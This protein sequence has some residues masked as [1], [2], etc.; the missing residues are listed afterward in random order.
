MRL[1]T[2]AGC[3]SLH[4]LCV[5]DNFLA[6]N[7]LALVGTMLSGDQSRSV[8]HNGWLLLPVLA[9]VLLSLATAEFATAQIHG[10]PPSVTSIQN[11]LPPY[12]PNIPP[13]VTSLGPKGAVGPPAFPVFP[14]FV[15]TQWGRRGHGNG[16]WNG[17]RFSGFGGTFIA[18]VFIP[19]G[20]GSYG[21]DSGGGAPYVYSGPPPEQ[22]L[23]I[24]VDIPAARAVA[25][26]DDE[27]TSPPAVASKSKGDFDP[28]SM[29]NAK[30]VE[31]TVL[32]F[33]DGH[34]QEVSNYAI[35]GQTVYVFDNRI[36]KIAL[37]DLDVSAT[38]KA[39]D[40]RGI[41]FLLPEAKKT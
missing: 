28:E 38:V 41:E 3:C 31:P 15:G 9:V 40:D 34:Q 6:S 1:S 26:A 23:H 4:L 8:R 21:D 22:A 5:G 2:S 20:D 16:F 19:I 18:P 29:G 13:S 27:D 7:G 36:Q 30:P 39:N 10:I 35:M 11:H 17:N 14:P 32:I 24:V 33:R 12:F 37:G 25:A